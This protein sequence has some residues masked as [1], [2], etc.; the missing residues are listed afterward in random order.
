MKKI[1]LLL[2][3]CGFVASISAQYPQTLPIDYNSFFATSAMG[4]DPTL[5]KAEYQTSTDAILADQWN[6]SGKL[7]SGE[8]GGSSPLVENSTLNY[9][10]YVDNNVGK[11]IILNPDIQPSEVA[12]STF[13]S[14]I[15][16]LTSGNQYRGTAFYLSLLVNFSSAPTSANDFLAWDANHTANSQRGRVFVK[17]VSGGIQF[18][19]GY[20][21]QPTGWSSTLAM[22][23]THLLV[24]KIIPSTTEQE[25]F[26]L[27]INPSIEATEEESSLL[28][29][30]TET[31]NTF[32]QIRGITIRQRPGIGGKLAGFRFSNSWADVVKATAAELPQL[33]AAAVGAA[34]SVGS[35]TFTANW[36]AVANATGYTVKVYQDETLHGSYDADGQSTESL[37]VSGLWVGTTY[38]YRI[39]AKGDG[40]NYSN[41]EESAASAGFTTSAGL[42]SIETDFTNADAW[43]EAN[44]NDLGLEHYPSSEINGYKLN[45]AYLRTGSIESLRGESL[46][47]RIAVDKNSFNGSITLPAV[48]SVQ[49]VEIHATSGS[50]D[51]GFKLEKTLNGKTWEVVGTY[52]TNKAIGIFTIPVSSDNPIKFR[53]A[54]NTTSALLVWK[55]ITRT[56][57]PALLATPEASAATAVTANGFTANWTAVVNASGYKVKV[58]SETALINT[59][60][61]SGQATESVVISDLSPETAYAYRVLA[62]G[63]GFVTYADSYVSETVSVTTSTVTGKQQIDAAKALTVSGNTIYAAQTGMLRIYDVSGARILQTSISDQ[64]VC[65]LN[66]G[67]YIIQLTTELGKIYSQK[68]RIQ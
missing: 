17:S 65:S 60:S 50:D 27:F 20:S 43:G 5:E 25:I 1:T 19:L 64:Y 15:Y 57:N 16:S 51:R 11:A 67:L 58:Y 41:S 13:R 47:N 28:T 29:T 54:N 53:I 46:Q 23:Q 18:G 22:N 24:L 61:V 26:S 56:T 62:T 59:C 44:P 37:A 38:T 63:D 8:G 48:Q 42:T 7:T 31:A 6:R 39:I 3:F 32:K 30:R 55:I 45:S 35:E 14:T 2:A 66:S 36:T 12:S 52:T 49:Q 40:E 34:S 9:S 21:G 10:N 68:I 4:T 33:S